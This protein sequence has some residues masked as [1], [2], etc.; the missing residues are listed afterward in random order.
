MCGGGPEATGVW[1]AAYL[2][3]AAYLSE[4]E[5]AKG[6]HKKA[7]GRRARKTARRNEKK[8][9]DAAEERVIAGMAML[10]AERTAFESL[11]KERAYP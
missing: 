10:S 1:A 4:I 5:A 9:L 6:T 3:W 11:Q 8:A 2:V 7:P